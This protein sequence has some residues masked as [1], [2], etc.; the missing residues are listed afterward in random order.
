M[1]GRKELDD[2]LDRAGQGTDRDVDAR[3]KTDERAHDRTGRGK[4][5]DAFEPGDQIEHGD[6][7][8]QGCE[9]DH[10][11]NLQHH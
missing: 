7:G 10:A 2:G 8:C 4:G 1:G 3:Q 11:Q 9:D 6:T 5:I